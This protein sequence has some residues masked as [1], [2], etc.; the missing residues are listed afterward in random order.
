MT[1]RANALGQRCDPR[2]LA[3]F[4]PLVGRAQPWWVQK[5]SRASA[6]SLSVM[7]GIAPWTLRVKPRCLVPCRHA[8]GAPLHTFGKPERPERGAR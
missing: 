5:S 3:P 7:H 4:L 2:G 8:A 6:S 1:I